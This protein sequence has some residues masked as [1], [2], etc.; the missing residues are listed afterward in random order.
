M[1]CELD[2]SKDA[3]RFKNSLMVILRYSV[4][5]APELHQTVVA[6]LG[7]VGGIA[8]TSLILGRRKNC[9]NVLLN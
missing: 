9:L 4:N 3:S 7:V 8:A 1:F 6:W 2:H 5:Q